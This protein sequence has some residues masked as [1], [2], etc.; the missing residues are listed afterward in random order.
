[1]LKPNGPKNLDPLPEGR[2]VSRDVVKKV[3]PGHFRDA[4]S[5]Y[6]SRE[7][8]FR[9][10]RRRCCRHGDLRKTR[11]RSPPLRTTGLTS[12]AL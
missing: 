5:N 4:V 12:D 2:T 11:D 10:L 1:M 6:A 8:T 7:R 9:T 3:S